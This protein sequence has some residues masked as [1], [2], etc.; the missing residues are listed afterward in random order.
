MLYTCSV[1]KTGDLRGEVQFLTG[2]KSE[3]TDESAT[4]R[5]QLNRCKP[6]TNSKVWMKEDAD[7]SLMRALKLSI[8]GLFCGRKAGSRN[9]SRSPERKGD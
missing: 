2:G 1:K 9:L 5:R 6:G 7:F 3:K 8:S 4:C